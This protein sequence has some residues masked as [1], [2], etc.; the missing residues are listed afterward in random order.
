MRAPGQTNCM[1]MN[2]ASVTF[3]HWTGCRMEGCFLTLTL[4]LVGVR[5]ISSSLFVLAAALPG[6]YGAGLVLPDALRSARSSVPC[7]GGR[8]DHTDENPL[9]RDTIQVCAIL[10]RS[11]SAAR[12]EAPRIR[13]GLTQ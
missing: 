11:P 5:T 13:P 2:G 1:L 9:D 3:G 6:A 10:A 7:S 8:L 12:R 4:M